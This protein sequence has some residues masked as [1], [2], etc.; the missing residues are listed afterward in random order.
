MSFLGKRFFAKPR[1]ITYRAIVVDG[2]RSID[3]QYEQ[4]KDYWGLA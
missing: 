1:L 3:E 4:V 2:K